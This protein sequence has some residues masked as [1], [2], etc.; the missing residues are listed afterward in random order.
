MNKGEGQRRCPK[1]KR[2]LLKFI[3]N[4]NVYCNACDE[5]ITKTDK[6]SGMKYVKCW[7]CGKEPIWILYEREEIVCPRCGVNIT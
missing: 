7:Y 5:L 1:C 6:S 4:G 3:K 2:F